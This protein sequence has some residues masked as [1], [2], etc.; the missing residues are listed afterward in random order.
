M[1]IDAHI[2]MA[3]QVAKPL[4]DSGPIGEWAGALFTLAGSR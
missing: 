1:L 4:L 2:H 3:T